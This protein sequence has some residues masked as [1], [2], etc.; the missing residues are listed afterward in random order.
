MKIIHHRQG[1]PKIDSDFPLAVPLGDVAPHNEEFPLNRHFQG[2]NAQIEV[3][4]VC[5][6]THDIRM[7]KMYIPQMH[8]KIKTNFPW[9]S[10][11]G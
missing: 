7:K 6:H 5:A 9:R 2:E 11:I 3:R 8:E 10:A 1:N 4:Q